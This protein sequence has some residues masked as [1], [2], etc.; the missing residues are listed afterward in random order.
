M[1]QRHTFLFGAVL[2]VAGAAVATDHYRNGAGSADAPPQQDEASTVIPAASPVV[3]PAPQPVNPHNGSAGEIIEFA[4]CSANM[5]GLMAAPPSA[6]QPAQESKTV[7]TP[8]PAPEST[9]TVPVPDSVPAPKPAAIPKPAPATP[10]QGRIIEF[11]PC[12][13]GF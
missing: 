10:Q 2:A 8:T 1:T 4:P 13:A 9:T 7:T 11:A 5:D 3:T 12:A 6:T